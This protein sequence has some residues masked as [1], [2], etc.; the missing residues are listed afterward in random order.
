MNS[1]VLTHFHKNLYHFLI[2]YWQ[3]E[4]AVILDLAVVVY[5]LILAVVMHFN[6]YDHLACRGTHKMF[7]HM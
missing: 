5:S 4:F 6:L 1:G 7:F 2:L 3:N